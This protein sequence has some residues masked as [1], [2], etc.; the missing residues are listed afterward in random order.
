MAKVPAHAA[1]EHPM[2]KAMAAGLHGP[3]DEAPADA[4]DDAVEI[5]RADR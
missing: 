5:R 1:G 4:E 3:D 2:F